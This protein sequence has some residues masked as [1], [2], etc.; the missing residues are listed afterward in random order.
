MYFT[1]LDP[2]VTAPASAAGKGWGFDF[3]QQDSNTLLI[4]VYPTGS[5]A[6]S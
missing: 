5:G 1:Y 6:G 2:A 3:S 4:D